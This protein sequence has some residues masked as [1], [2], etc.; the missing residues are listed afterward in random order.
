MKREIPIL[1]FVNCERTVLFSVKRDLDPPRRMDDPPP[2]RMDAPP[3]RMEDP[4]RRMVVVP[5]GL[6]P[7]I[8]AEIPKNH[9]SL[10]IPWTWWSHWYA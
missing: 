10:G 7:R 4:T 1:F 5:D 6:W 3:R 8:E 9:S 2:R